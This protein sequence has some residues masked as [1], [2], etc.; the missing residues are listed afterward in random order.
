MGADYGGAV[1][2]QHQTKTPSLIRERLR[3]LFLRS[4][5]EADDAVALPISDD[6]PVGEENTTKRRRVVGQERPVGH[7]RVHKGL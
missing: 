4:E 5:P 6:S 2:D 3:P 1:P 7:C